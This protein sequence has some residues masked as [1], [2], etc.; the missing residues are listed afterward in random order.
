MQQEDNPEKEANN[1]NQIP[2]MLGQ[3]LKEI[4]LHIFGI[5]QRLI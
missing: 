1:L 5:N 3:W 2:F 4:F